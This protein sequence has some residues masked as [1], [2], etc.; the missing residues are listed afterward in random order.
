MKL[1][2]FL[3]FLIFD[4][5]CL[6]KKAN[7]LK[8]IEKIKKMFNFAQNIR[9][10]IVPILLLSLIYMKIKKRHLK[11]LKDF[12]TRHKTYL[13]ETNE[14]FVSGSEIINLSNFSSG[15]MAHFSLS[16]NN[17]LHKKKIAINKEKIAI[18]KTII[19]KNIW[20]GNITNI[21]FENIK[22]GYLTNDSTS[23]T[24]ILG[25]NGLVFIKNL[26][27]MEFEKQMMILNNNILSGAFNEVLDEKSSSEDEFI[28]LNPN[29]NL[30]QIFST[31]LPVFKKSELKVLPQIRQQDIYIILMHGLITS[32]L[33]SDSDSD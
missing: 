13:H 5:F 16:K 26:N 28:Y 8:K 11:K 12:E 4:S 29:H 33:N 2:Y 27:Q 30:I 24:C 17:K 23:N 6:F 14:A 20:N 21:N 18:N 25:I 7:I 22:I 1:K 15:L 32:F 19:I 31:P 10:E 9:I 3:L